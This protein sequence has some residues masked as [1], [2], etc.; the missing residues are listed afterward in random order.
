MNT[1]EKKSSIV[2]IGSGLGGL[3]CGAILSREGFHVTVLE[4]NR[5]IGGNLQTYARD[6]HIFDSGVHYLGSLGKGQNLYRVFKFLG[7]MDHIRLE[8]MDPDGFD[9]I[10]F[11]GDDKVYRFAQ[12]WEHFRNTLLVDFPD[13]SEAI[14]TYCYTIRKICDRFPL[15]NLREGDYMEKSEFLEID[16]R[17][18]LESI[19]RNGKLQN[20]LAGNSSLY[21]GVAGKTPVYVHAL[22]VNSY[23]ESAWRVIDGGSV[24]A[25]LLSKIITGAGGQIINRTEVVKLVCENDRITHALTDGGNAFHGDHFISNMHPAQTLKITDSDMIR[26]AYRNRIESLEN[27]TSFFVMNVTLKPGMF[28]YE[29]SNYYC[30]TNDQ[31]WDSINYDEMNWPLYYGLFFSVNHSTGE[32][33]DGVTIMS[34]MSYQEV[35]Q[36]HNTF[37][38]VGKP[39]K[40]GDEYEMFKKQKAEKLLSVVE[41]KF[42]GFRNA[43]HDYYTSTPLTF[44]DYMG[45]DDG[46]VYG[47]M[48]DYK[49]PL[50]TFISP[51]TKIPN[52][53]MTGQNI[54]LHGILGVTISALV[55]C[56]IFTGMTELLKK[57]ESAQHE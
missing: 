28:R 51:R 36:W 26:P 31:V 13:E 1:P 57:I 42:P 45:T 34:Y 49:N 47:I 24:I 48:K 40:R 46:S 39:G 37:N 16:T 33:A 29:R 27:S 3:I 23:I 55:T 2:I 52:L 14:D 15:Y 21:A 30:F 8:K 4:R 56:S 10:L 7:I 6:K 38:T 32:F 12:G 44:R 41:H 53:Y 20:V 54:N 5:Q 35:S 43:I 22:V 19:T 17:Q 11:H 9:K 18:F 50:K 25:R